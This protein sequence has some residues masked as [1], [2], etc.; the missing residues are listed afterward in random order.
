MLAVLKNLR[1]AFSSSRNQFNKK[2]KTN[3]STMSTLTPN[4]KFDGIMALI[5]GFSLHLTLGTLYCFGNLNTYMTSYLRKH[6]NP[7]IEYSDMIWIPT[8]ATLGQVRIW[9]K[10]YGTNVSTSTVF[11]RVCS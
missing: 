10:L 2:T 5:G 1:Y 9:L 11:P 4:Q 3:T 7:N 8:L 6:V